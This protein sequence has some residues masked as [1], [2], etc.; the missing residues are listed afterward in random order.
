MTATEGGRPYRVIVTGWRDWPREDKGAVE[1]FIEWHTLSGRRSRRPLVIVQ[2][3]CDKGGVD[4]YADEWA[5]ANGWTSEGHPADWQALGKSA[6]PLRNAHMVELGADLCLA[7][8]GLRA[9]SNGFAR[10]GTAGCLAMAIAAGIPTFV[11][12]YARVQTMKERK[13]N[14]S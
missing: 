2:G 4:Q 3:E 6:G 8:P 12:P 7:F 10:S 5:A 14:P 9:F 1:K 11:L 13:G